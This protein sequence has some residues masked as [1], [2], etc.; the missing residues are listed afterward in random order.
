MYR[1]PKRH[2]GERKQLAREVVDGLNITPTMYTF[3]ERL[4]TGLPLPKISVPTDFCVPSTSVA[5]F[6]KNIFG[7]QTRFSWISFILHPLQFLCI[8]LKEISAESLIRISFI[9]RWAANQFSNQP[10]FTNFWSWA[11]YRC[12]DVLKWNVECSSDVYGHAAQLL[13]FHRIQQWTPVLRNP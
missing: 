2:C 6:W 12:M 5:M 9:N 4:G 10:F 8:F 1:S 3:S 13:Y 7:P 11:G